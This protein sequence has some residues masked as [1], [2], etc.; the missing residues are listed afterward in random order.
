MDFEG[1]HWQNPGIENNWP[2]KY[3]NVEQTSYSQ[4]HNL[5]H[6]HDNDKRFDIKLEDDN[7]TANTKMGLDDIENV[8]SRFCDGFCVEILR[9]SSF[10]SRLT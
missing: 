7:D 4:C 10:K 5:Y 8:L 2:D 3:W 9:I 1:H 6:S